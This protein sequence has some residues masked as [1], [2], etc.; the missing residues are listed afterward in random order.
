MLVYLTNIKQMPNWSKEDITLE[1]L[2]DDESRNGYSDIHTLRLFGLYKDE[3]RD[4]RHNVYHPIDYV[5]NDVRIIIGEFDSLE[6]A[7]IN[8]P[9]NANIVKELDRDGNNSILRVKFPIVKNRHKS[10]HR[11]SYAHQIF[12]KLAQDERVLFCY[13]TPS[14][15]GLRFG[16]KLDTRINNDLEYIS[17]YYFYAKKL[18]TYDKEDKL[19]IEYNAST[20]GS[21]YELGNVASVYWFLPTTD[22]WHVKDAVE[23]KKI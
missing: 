2:F 7:F 3:S 5:S 8:K 12:E 18:L 11:D 10:Y 13:I 20:T 16:F 23:V 14:G 19:T 22:K 1:K 15:K 9:D 6:T 4:V 21:F 17:N